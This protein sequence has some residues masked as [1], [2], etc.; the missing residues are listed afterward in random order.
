MKIVYTTNAGS[1][2]KYAEMLSSKLACEALSLEETESAGGEEII[3]IGW[4]MAGTIQGL[5]QA[6]EK[7][8]ELKAV[9]AVGMMP[10]EK[11]KEE[12]IAKNA[13]KE[14]FFLLPG[15]FHI[16]KLKGMYKMMMGMMMKM[17][18]SKL[19]E[20]D[21]PKAKEAAELFEKGFDAVKEENLEPVYEWLGV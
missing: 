7:L 6:R 4:V 12:L 18:K 8:G 1:S 14:E 15:D 2:K 19:K 11:Q 9:C 20:S 21:D 10:G 5:A 16:D 3:Y 13:V 17:L